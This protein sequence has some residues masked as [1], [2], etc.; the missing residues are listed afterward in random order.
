MEG[1]LFNTR[2]VT[3]FAGRENDT[4]DQLDDLNSLA[5]NGIVLTKQVLSDNVWVLNPVGTNVA[6]QPF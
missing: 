2:D 4:S 6:T 1:A 3:S 5:L